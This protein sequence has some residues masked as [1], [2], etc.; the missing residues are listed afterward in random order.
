[1]ACEGTTHMNVSTH[2]FEKF[3]FIY[4]FLHFAT[5]TEKNWCPSWNP[6]SH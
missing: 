5:D 2:V 4:D 1:M 3:V 6:L